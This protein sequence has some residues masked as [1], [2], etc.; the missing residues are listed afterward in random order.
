MTGADPLTGG[1]PESAEISRLTSELTDAKTLIDDGR[2]IIAELRE[3]L[4]MTRNDLAA[5][6]AMVAGLEKIHGEDRET[7]GRLERELADEKRE[8]RISGPYPA[9]L[10]AIVEAIRSVE[11]RVDDAM[12]RL[13]EARAHAKTQRVDH[14]ALKIRVTR[15]E[16]KPR[17][18]PARKA[19]R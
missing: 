12:R 19:K 10:P 15:L 7:V 14:E 13:N 3:E 4:S 8:P 17:T 9:N 1:N 6:N 18:K 5:S 16:R 2:A 11:R